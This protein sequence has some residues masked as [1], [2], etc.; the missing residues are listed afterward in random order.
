[1]DN[2]AFQLSRI[3]GLGWNAGKKLLAEGV[4]PKRAAPPNPYTTIEERGRWSQGFEA[5]LRSRTGTHAASNVRSW[6]PQGRR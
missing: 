5:A 2:G 1:M 6:R 4:D 3:Y